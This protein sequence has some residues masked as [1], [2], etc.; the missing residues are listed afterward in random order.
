MRFPIYKS[1]PGLL[2]IAGLAL[3]WFFAV[4]IG[5]FLGWIPL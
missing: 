4:G 5:S 2:W 1:V 3:I